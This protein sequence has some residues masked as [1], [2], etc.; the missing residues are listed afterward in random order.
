MASIGKTT[1]WR[2]LSEN[3]LRPWRHRSWIFPRDPD[4]AEKAGRVLDLYEGRWAGKALGPK[5]FVLSADEKTSIQPRP[6][7]HPTLPP[8][9]GRTMRVEHEYTRKGSWA[10]LAAW[11]VHRAKIFGRCELRS[12]IEPFGRLVHQVMTKQPYRSARRVFWIVDNG[13]S[14]RGQRAMVRLQETWPTLTLVHTPVHASWL[15]QVEIY[16]SIVQ[17][18][19][20][21][22]SNFRSLD[23]L[24][25]CLLRFQDYYQLVASPF[26]W[27]FSRR[28]LAALLDRLAA[29]EQPLDQAA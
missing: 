21:T 18:K 12:G 2:W 22:P 24:K 1:I 11:D 16:F 15:N 25:R 27:K 8:A 7:H 4:F 13:S 29:H 9:P 17:R 10:Y 3:A 6:R 28:D 19:I 20:L 23:E 26:E 14:H 5:E